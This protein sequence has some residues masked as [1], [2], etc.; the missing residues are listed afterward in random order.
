MVRLD[1]ETKGHLAGYMST[2]QGQIAA[3]AVYQ[4]PNCQSFNEVE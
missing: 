3:Y 2:T 1:Y 4:C